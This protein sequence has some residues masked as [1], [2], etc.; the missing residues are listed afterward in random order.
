MTCYESIRKKLDEV[1]KQDKNQI[2]DKLTNYFRALN[3]DKTDEYH[4]IRG[5]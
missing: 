4:R 1:D 2:F 5:R 3:E